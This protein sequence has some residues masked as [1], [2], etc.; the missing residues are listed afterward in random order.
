MRE[1]IRSARADYVCGVLEQADAH[2]LDT[3]VR[4][5][6]LAPALFPVN[7]GLGIGGAERRS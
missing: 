4:A 6:R 3:T 2:D 7:Y 1:R 5:L